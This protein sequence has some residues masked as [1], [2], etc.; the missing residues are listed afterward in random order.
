MSQA[1]CSLCTSPGTNKVNCPLNPDAKN[2]NTKQHPRARQWRL[3]NLS[4]YSEQQLNVVVSVEIIS[5]EN[6]EREIYQLT[7]LRAIDL[8]KERVSNSRGQ[9]TLQANRLI[10]T[11]YNTRSAAYVT[12]PRPALEIIHSAFHPSDWDEYVY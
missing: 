11:D 10:F 2:P 5:P 8:L 4:P 9:L 1:T 12:G 6:K 3:N 7:L